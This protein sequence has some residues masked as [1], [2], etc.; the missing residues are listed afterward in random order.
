M[1]S[2]ISSNFKCDWDRN[3]RSLVLGEGQ[4]SESGCQVGFHSQRLGKP[5]PTSPHEEGTLI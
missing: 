4:L 2:R 5:C 3:V 1:S